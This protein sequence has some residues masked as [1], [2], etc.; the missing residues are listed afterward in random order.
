M[1]GIIQDGD[2]GMMDDRSPEA[3]LEG[4]SVASHRSRFIILA[5]V[6]SLAIGYMIYAAFPGNTRYF[7]TVS[8]FMDGTE[9][10]DGQMVRVSGKL[11]EESFLRQEGSTLSHFQ[12]A[13]KDAGSG[14]PVNASYVGVM[15]DLFFNPHSAIILEGRYT[16]A[17]V[18]EADS[19][20]V[21][22]PS[23]YQS[24]EEEQNSEGQ[25]LEDQRQ[26]RVTTSS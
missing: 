26:L 18:F 6:V 17:Q 14:V 20:L 8:E 21:K 22:C 23:K 13:D 4:S 15:P 25:K 19:I 1:A 7:L 12:L 10:Q 5:V 11:V 9:F 16:S 3:A 24:L 2:Q